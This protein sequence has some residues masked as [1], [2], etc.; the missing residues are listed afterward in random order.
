MEVVDVHNDNTLCTDN[1][2]E[3]VVVLADI[4]NSSSCSKRKSMRILDSLSSNY[5]RKQIP[6]TLFSPKV[7]ATKL[8]YSGTKHTVS[9]TKHPVSATKLSLSTSKLTGSASTQQVS[10]TKQHCLAHQVLKSLHL[11]KS[12]ESSQW[13]LSPS[14]SSKVGRGITSPLDSSRGS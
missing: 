14:P 10:A 6:A 2:I 1:N 11:Q 5:K 7:S 4:G 9:G 8:T 3:A 12:R 13:I